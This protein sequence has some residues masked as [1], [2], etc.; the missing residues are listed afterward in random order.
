M[1][2]RTPTPTARAL[3]PNRACTHGTRVH[4]PRHLPALVLPPTLPPSRI[5]KH[6]SRPFAFAVVVLDSAMPHATGDLRSALLVFTQ[7]TQHQHQQQQQQPQ[8]SHVTCHMSHVSRAEGRAHRPVARCPVVC[9]RHHKPMSHECPPTLLH[10]PHPPLHPC[11]ANCLR[12]LA[13]VFPREGV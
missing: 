7:C 3:H 5:S 4:H 11:S 9:H 2:L 8:G 10:H 13:C 12:V 1:H 6:D